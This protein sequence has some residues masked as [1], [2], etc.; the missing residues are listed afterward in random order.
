MVVLVLAGCQTDKHA[1]VTV[2]PSSAVAS[3]KIYYVFD[4]NFR[5]YFGPEGVAH[6]RTSLARR[7]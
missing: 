2:D 1:R 7:E 6:C 3:S 5:N 4:E